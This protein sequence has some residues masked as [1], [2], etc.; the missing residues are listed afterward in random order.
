MNLGVYMDPQDGFKFTQHIVGQLPGIRH[1]VAEVSS[2]SSIE[3]SGYSK[4]QEYEC[5]GIYSMDVKAY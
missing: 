3:Y 1:I 5:S 4:K 2:I